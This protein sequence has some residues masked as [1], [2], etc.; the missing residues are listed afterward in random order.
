MEKVKGII[1]SKKF[2]NS[3]GNWG[4]VFSIRRLTKIRMPGSFANWRKKCCDCGNSW[5]RR[6]LRPKHKHNP[7]RSTL[8]FHFFLIVSFRAA[9]TQ[10][11]FSHNMCRYS[12]QRPGHS[13]ASTTSISLVGRRDRAVEG[14]GKVDCRAEWNV[15]RK[16]EKNGRNP[17]AKVSAYK[18]RNSVW[19]PF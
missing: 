9:M 2:T 15:G 4:Q 16:A 14:V 13:G 19:G 1:N 17:L 8:F 6:A 11:K 18:G 12:C 3:N 10:Q 7:V 5:R